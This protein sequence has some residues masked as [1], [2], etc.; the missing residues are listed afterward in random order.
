MAERI[1]DF[2]VRTNAMQQVQV[3]E[4]LR[5][6]KAGDTRSFGEI[7]M[8]LGFVSKAALDAFATSK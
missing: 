7:A 1:G 8:A 2:L 4:V 6:Q 5:A 3:D